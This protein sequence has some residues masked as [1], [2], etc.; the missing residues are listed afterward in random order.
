MTLSEND[1]VFVE[2]V[3]DV[4]KVFFWKN[5][6]FRAINK[7][8]VQEI[9]TLLSS[10]LIAELVQRK[11]FPKT[12]IAGEIDLDGF[13]FILEHE[14][15]EYI[16]RPFEWSY[17]MLRDICL[18]Y[19]DVYQICEK[20]GYTLKDGHLLNLTFFHNH[21]IFF[22]LGSIVRGFGGGG[23]SELYDSG[24]LPLRIW[25]QGDFYIANLILR[26]EFSHNRFLPSI[27]LRYQKT[28]KHLEPFVV[29]SRSIYLRDMIIRLGRKVFKKNNIFSSDLSEELLRRSF[30]KCKKVEGKTTWS[31]Y[32]DEFLRNA[33][34]SSGR[35]GRIIEI[36]KS[37]K[38]N[39]MVDLAGNK[40]GFSLLV[41]EKTNVKQIY[42]T[43]YDEYAVDGLYINLKKL[44]VETIN[45]V[46]LNFMC[47]VPESSRQVLMADIAV[48][49]AVVH[50]L[51]LTQSFSI[52]NILSKI[53]AHSRRF[54][55]VEFM[56]LGL[57]NGYHAPQVPEWYNVEWF[58]GKFKKHFTLLVEEKTEPNRILFLGEIVH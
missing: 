55:L 7:H 40:G 13:D 18:A 5:R 50:H 16:S 30:E 41:S 32:H 33:Q 56:P 28:L 45:P 39:S 14:K 24:G 48:A 1:V 10:G 26:D 4:G 15:I 34:D 25:S 36:L 3:D 35:F 51:L 8:K 12:T 27:A 9:K 46:L 19:L 47:P 42:C 58:R 6:V 2:T 21:A 20:Y 29:K 11:L 22:D 31:D 37:I 43:D 57:W 53:A 38:I 23:L 54:V 52:D 17:H 44:G 49:L